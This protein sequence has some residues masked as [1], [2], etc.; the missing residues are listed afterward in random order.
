[1]I[2][3]PCP[4]CHRNVG[5]TARGLLYRHANCPKSGKPVGRIWPTRHRGR[6]VRTIPGPDTWSPSSLEGAA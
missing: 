4:V 2:R 6:K 1:V 3:I 5:M